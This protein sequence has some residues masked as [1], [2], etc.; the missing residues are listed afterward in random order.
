[1]N[2]ISFVVP[3]EPVA[4]ARPRF[5]KNGH[6]YTPDRT[7]QYE[8]IVRLYA[9]RAMRGKKMLTGAISLSVV[10]FF[11]IP[12]YFTKAIREKALAGGLWHTKKPDWDNIGKIVS[13][14]LNGV[15]YP[16]D[17]VVSDATVAKRYSSNPRVVVTVIEI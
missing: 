16:D 7:R 6:A 2:R 12:K 15:V 5:T 1:M 9:I 17:A 8:E 13:D 10:A 11:P 3:G 14:A 4:K